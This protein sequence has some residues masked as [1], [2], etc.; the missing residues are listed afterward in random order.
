MS[1]TNS[2]EIKEMTVPSTATVD[3]AAQELMQ[4]LQYAR[5]RLLLRLKPHKANIDQLIKWK[6]R[7]PLIADFIDQEFNKRVTRNQKKEDKNVS[8]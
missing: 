7:H 8:N 1:P 3:V 6:R 4:K 2:T 5:Q